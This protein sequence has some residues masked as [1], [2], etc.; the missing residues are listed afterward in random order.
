[1][2]E[3]GE[4]LTQDAKQA[5][6]WYRKRQKA[7][8]Q[9]HP[10]A[11]SNLG[12]MHRNGK[13]VTHDPKKAVAWNRKAA[14]QGEVTAQSNLGDMYE[15]GK[16]VTQNLKKAVGWY[17]KSAELGNAGAQANL[18]RVPRVASEVMAGNDQRRGHRTRLA[19]FYVWRVG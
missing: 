6:T 10:S 7:A 19:A 17:R 13:G 16:G 14:G 18:K 8:A 3:K 11:Q 15:N 2:Y 12:R 9:R 4:G 1:M 5:V